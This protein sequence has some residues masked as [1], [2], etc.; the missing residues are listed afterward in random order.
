MTDTP[1][2]NGPEQRLTLVLEFTG[3]S[4]GFGC[5]RRGRAA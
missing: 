3:P 1:E 4:C 5:G 2:K